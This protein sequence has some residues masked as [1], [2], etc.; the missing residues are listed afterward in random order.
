[1]SSWIIKISLLLGTMMV[2]AAAAPATACQGLK[3]NS[4]ITVWCQTQTPLCVHND[5][6]YPRC[7]SYEFEF[8]EYIRK[9]N[10]NYSP[11][12]YASRFQ[13]FKDNIDFIREIN[14]ENDWIADINQYADLTWKEFQE[15]MTFQ[16]FHSSKR[17]SSSGSHSSHAGFAHDSQSLDWRQKGIVARIKDQSLDADCGSCWAFSSISALESRCALK[18]GE[19]KTLSEQQLVDCSKDYGNN[20]CDG[21]NFDAA[22]EYII[23]S[24]GVCADTVY[25]YKSRD[26]LPCNSTSRCNFCKM[27]EYVQLEENENAMVKALQSGPIVIGFEVQKSFQ[28]YRNSIYKQRSCG[29]SLNHGM[30]IVGYTPDYW[31]VRNSWGTSWGN[32]GYAHVA[33]GANVCGINRAS[34]YPVLA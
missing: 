24:G 28:F 4:K 30:V 14:S 27:S 2:V 21:G 6:G 25:P 19:L 11:A 29:N 31:I 18:T 34:C 23:N 1:M 13:V 8:A 16:D 3:E 10:K 32:D 5:N 12:E 7:S 17:P 20:G 22:Y 15:F 26:D 9:H 33:R